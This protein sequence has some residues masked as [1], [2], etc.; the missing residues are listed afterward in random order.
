MREAITPAQREKLHQLMSERRRHEGGFGR[1]GGP[2]GQG[3]MR[4]QGRAP[5]PDTQGQTQPKN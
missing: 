1:P 4:Q 3:R 2:R 5:A